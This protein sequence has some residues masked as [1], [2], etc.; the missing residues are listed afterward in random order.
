MG[1]APFLCLVVA[2]GCGRI[3]FGVRNDDG[4]RRGDSRSCTAEVCN[5]ID[6][7]CDGK[8]DE[9]CGCTPFSMAT[10]DTSSNWLVSTGDGWV[11]DNG[12]AFERIADDGTVT[13]GASGTVVG[14]ASG[15]AV[16]DGTHLVFVGANNALQFA[17]ADG[18]I[19]AQGPSLGFQN[20]DLGEVNANDHGFDV[21]LAYH[22]YAFIETDP[23]GAPI[24]STSI[25]DDGLPRTPTGLT[26]R[27]GAP[28]ASWYT[29]GVID[30]ASPD[31]PNQLAPTAL[32]L[33]GQEGG[34][35]SD[36]HR[37]LLVNSQLYRI[38]GADI[39]TITPPAGETFQTVGW[40]GDGWDVVAYT[41][42][43]NEY[44][45]H[46][47]HY[48]ASLAMTSDTIVIAAPYNTTINGGYPQIATD[49]RRTLVT[50]WIVSDTFGG[51]Y[52]SATC[53]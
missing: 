37:V 52:L 27:D 26:T 10:P 46:L 30:V 43:P 22:E 36:G 33:G 13:V 11:T 42:I 29:N 21:A 2:A 35:A 25:A 5:G 47:L 28:F 15:P 53:H 6:D 34:I 23:S 8:I 20:G 12:M 18:T 49:A 31:P 19:V 3:S 16:W 41:S 7:D 50:W 45:L 48:D 39:T 1:H 40:T 51:T 17:M 9:G 14:A 24:A 38:D 32:P 44:D 4:A